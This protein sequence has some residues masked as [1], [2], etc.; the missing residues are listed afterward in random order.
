MWKIPGTDPQ[1]FALA[2]EKLTPLSGQEK[3]TAKN[4]FV[5]IRSHEP[6]LRSIATDTWEVF[7][8]TL[9]KE[10]EKDTAQEIGLDADS[11]GAANKIRKSTTRRHND[12]IS[13]LEELK[14]PGMA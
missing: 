2:T 12:I 9:Y 6:A 11:P 8:D 10:L 3:E 7:A 1:L 5:F 14:V 13:K 4:A